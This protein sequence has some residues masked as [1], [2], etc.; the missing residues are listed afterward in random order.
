MDTSKIKTTLTDLFRRAK[1]KV[2]SDPYMARAKKAAI[3]AGGAALGGPFLAIGALFGCFAGGFIGNGFAWLGVIA[4][5]AAA[6]ACVGI[7]LLF[8][9]VGIPIWLTALVLYLSA[10][11]AF[12]WWMSAPDKVPAPGAKQA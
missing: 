9:L 11:L 1:R 8:Q 2:D 5:G 10:C 6:A 3:Y 4:W 12:G 7:A